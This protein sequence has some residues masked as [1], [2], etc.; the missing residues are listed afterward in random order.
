LKLNKT[1]NYDSNRIIRPPQLLIEFNEPSIELNESFIEFNA[2][3]IEFN[4][5]SIEFN[6]SFIEFNELSIEFNESFIEFNESYIEFNESFIEFNESYIHANYS[7]LKQMIMFDYIPRKDSELAAWSAN[8]TAQVA[9]N[10]GTWNTPEDE[11][12]DVRRL[13]VHFRDLDSES[14]ARPYGT[15]GAVI[16]YA[17]LDAP[18][19]LTHS[20]PA[21]RTPHILEFTGQE[22]GR[23]VYLAICRQNEKGEKGPPSEIESAIVP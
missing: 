16:F 23:T 21:T 19:D 10:L 1:R 4:E 8:F 22:R 18:A 7:L 11:V 5:L 3:S 15:N 17:V 13:K 20:V 2:F 6:E 9:G 12:L 14:K